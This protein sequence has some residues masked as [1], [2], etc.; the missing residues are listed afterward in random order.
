MAVLFGA[1]LNDELIHKQSVLLS[2]K[3]LLSMLYVP[4]HLIYIYCL[5]FTGK[6]LIGIIYVN[7]FPV[8]YF[9][10]HMLL[11]L[12]LYLLRALGECLPPL[13]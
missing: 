2:K 8:S 11:V 5:G 6:C 4:R 10:M 13:K 3:K 9:N 12:F 7:F 1:R